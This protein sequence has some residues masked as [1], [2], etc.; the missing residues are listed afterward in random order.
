MATLAQQTASE[1]AAASQ[2]VPAAQP[3]TPAQ[4][5]STPTPAPSCHASTPPTSAAPHCHSTVTTSYEGIKLALGATLTVITWISWL[6]PD[7]SPLHQPLLMGALATIVIA[8]TGWPILVSGWRSI[9][10]LSPN[11][12]TLISL[13][14]VTAWTWSA[15]TIIAGEEESNHFAM[16]AAIIV[17]V[18]FGGWLESRSQQRSNDALTKLANISVKVARLENGTDIPIENLKVGMRFIVRPGENIPTD[19][20]VAA[21]KSAVDTSLL[22]GEPLPVEVA[23]GSEVI[24]TALNTTAVLTVEATRVGAETAHA[25]LLRLLQEA[26]NSKAPVQ[27][28]VDRASAIFV[29]SVVTVAAVVLLAWLL[30]GADS[31]KA[32]AASVAVLVVACPCALGLASPT[33]IVAGVG[34]A[35]KEGIVIRSGDVWEETPRINTIVVDKTGTLTYGAP[36]VVEIV[37][38]ERVSGEATAV[39]TQAAGQLATA[40]Q[41]PT[42]TEIP[43]LQLSQMAYFLASHSLHP[44]AKAVAQ[45]CEASE[46]SE[47]SPDFSDLQI[48]EI[49][50]QGVCA[51]K[52]E[53]TG[54]PNRT[55]AALGAASLFSH[56]PADLQEAADSATASGL[57][58]SFTGWQPDLDWHTQAGGLSPEAT[59]AQVTA[60][61]P[62]T[63]AAKPPATGLFVLAD[64]LRPGAAHTVRQLQSDG[65]SVVMLTGDTHAGA[66]IV[67]QKIKPDEIIAQARPEDKLNTVRQLQHDGRKVAVV[68]DGINDAAALAQANLGIAFSSGSDVALAAS[69]ITLMSHNF[70][71]VSTALSIAK[72]TRS[73]IASNLIWACIYNA[74]A[75]PLAAVGLLPPAAAAA[76]MSLSSLCVVG[77]SLRLSRW[78]LS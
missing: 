5:A 49:A 17:F 26:Q 65:F 15:W 41:P 8:I 45:K 70:N 56:I 10:N 69:D 14:V 76:A 28:L 29:P 46:S 38:A 40:T 50:G 16:A 66:E 7:S 9:P 19:G 23:P 52:A 36:A 30:A 78:K 64:E 6:L 47:S 42:T 51:T 1:P 21:G 37:V 24:G 58:L 3:T 54:H 61:K 71:S 53:H 34:R 48:S 20:V 27:R 59:E 75:L 74:A 2:A 18:R 4:A 12:D 44:L 67:A 68:G 11:M 33:A 72:H 25:Q 60:P 31:T 77:N 22:T 13:G 73:T 63:A 39:E 32:I 57:S 55:I 43:D 62:Q 35:A